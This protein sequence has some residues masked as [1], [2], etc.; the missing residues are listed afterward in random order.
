LAK[1]YGV[2]GYPTILFLDTDGQK[3]GRSGYLRGGAKVWIDNA[4][5]IIGNRP[6]PE[7]LKVAASLAEGTKQAQ[8]TGHPLFLLIRHPGKPALKKATDSAVNSRDFIKLANRRLIVVEPKLPFKADS[9]EQKL[10]A[11]LIR[12][13]KLPDG[14]NFMAL[15]NLQD[16]TVTVYKPSALLRPGAM[17]RVVRKALPPIRYDGGWI[18]DFELAQMIA[19][20]HKRAMLLDFTGSDWCGWCIKLDKEV[21]STEEFR[22]YAAKNLVLVKIDFPQKKQQSPE[23]KRKNNSLARKFGVEGFP[24]LII[25]SPNGKKLGQIGYQAGGPG[26]FL[27]KLNK[28]SRAKRINR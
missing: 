16:D 10:L 14:P 20:D 3:I 15:L 1:S 6:K 26:P 19:A 2:R 5:K 21:F 8:S 18:E 13:F 28:L 12:R 11:E 27:R 4:Q 7:V 9:S 23:Q 24:T 25:L 17:T 22:K